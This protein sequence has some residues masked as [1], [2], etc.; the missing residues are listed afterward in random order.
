[1]L[2]CIARLFNFHFV[3]CYTEDKGPSYARPG[4]NTSSTVMATLYLLETNKSIPEALH[5]LLEFIFSNRVL[6]KMANM[7]MYF[8][9]S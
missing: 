5:Q 3:R 8:Q 6:K 4:E 1:M 9:A 7:K 2:S